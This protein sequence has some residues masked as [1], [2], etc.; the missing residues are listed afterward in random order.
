ME[1][2]AEYINF[3]E[4]MIYFTLIIGDIVEQSIR[5]SNIEEYEKNQELDK[6]ML[7][8]KKHQLFNERM[9]MHKR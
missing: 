1:F 9:E 6:K 8:I 7:S 3:T 2:L 4:E 5:H